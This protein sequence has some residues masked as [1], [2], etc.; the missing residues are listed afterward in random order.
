APQASPE[1][2]RGAPAAAHQEEPSPGV[3]VAIAESAGELPREDWFVGVNGVPLGP[4]PLADL[5]ELAVAGHV[6]RRSLVWREGFD[7]WK[8]LGKLPELLRVVDRV[9]PQSEMPERPGPS[10]APVSALKPSVPK[11]PG[12]PAQ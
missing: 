9:A 12:L 5:C 2:P 3:E 8:P 6:D 11:A 4:I 1:P 7:E 10:A